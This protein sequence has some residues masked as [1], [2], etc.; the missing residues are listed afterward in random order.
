MAKGNYWEYQDS[1]LSVK[2]GISIVGD[3]IMSNGKTYSIFSIKDLLGKST[4]YSYRRL[5]SD[6]ILYIWSGN[7]GYKYYDFTKNVSESWRID[8]VYNR[9]LVK[10]DSVW[11]QLFGN[12]LPR[13]EFEDLYFTTNNDT[14][15]I[16]RAWQQIYKG[17]GDVMLGELG[18][19]VELV[20][21]IINNRSYG[22]ITSVQD[23]EYI[24]SS[25]V[26][27]QNYPN[28]FN[29][30]TIISY[31]IPGGV[32]TLHATS[33]RIYDMLGREVAT[34]VNE[35]KP[36]G[37]YSVTFN[38]G[39]LHGAYLPSGIYF[40]QLRAGDYAETKKMMLIK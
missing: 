12:I 40:Y 38:V 4:R 35:A 2:T 22:T 1:G 31:T 18:G 20:G 29:P 6:S 25:F 7:D 30:S 37:N 13:M 10:K 15:Y 14:V 34:L 33:L 21:A 9:R 8:S 36:A 27:S 11:S 24:S 39:T 28:P 32:E 5:E 16:E 19:Y 17:V 3:T 26:L 23:E